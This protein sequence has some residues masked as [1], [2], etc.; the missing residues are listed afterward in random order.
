MDDWEKIEDGKAMSVESREEDAM[1]NYRRHEQ[2]TV[3]KLGLESRG[4][5]LRKWFMKGANIMIKCSQYGLLYVTLVYQQ[6]I[7]NVLLNMWTNV[8]Q[9]YKYKK[10]NPQ[11]I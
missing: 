3:L 6:L 4:I 11:F 7:H 2:E 10:K 1:I 5:I 9:G 8:L